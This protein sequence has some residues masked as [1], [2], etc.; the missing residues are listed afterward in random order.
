MP[1]IPE[2]DVIV[3]GG[4]AGGIAAAVS[5]ARNGAR[6][7]LFD[8]YGFLGGGATAML[9]NPFMPYWAGRT[10]IIHGVLQEII[11]RL[12][13]MGAYGHPKCEAAFDP[14][15]F[16]VVAELL[17]QEAGV[18]LLYHSVLAGVTKDGDR[19]TAVKVANKAGL[20]ELKAKLFIDSTGDGDLSAMAGA[21][22]EKG[23]PEDGL[24]QPMTL[25]FRVA[26]IDL[27]RMPSRGEVTRLYLEAKANGEIQ[28]PR[29]D[30]LFF[31]TTQ[32]GVIHFN[33][34]RVV[35][36]DAT[37]PW[38]LTEAEIEARRQVQ[39]YMAFFR[40]HVR[41]FENAYLQTTAPNI[42]VRESRRVIG[43][44]VLTAEELM[45]KC[46][47]DDVIAL[48]SYPIDIHNPAGT[49]T[50]LKY[51]QPGEYY[52]L[53]YRIL[54][55]KGV[56]NLLVGGRCVSCTHEAHSA[57]RVMPIVMAMA[58]AAGTAAAI[59]LADGVTPGQVDVRKLQARL[60]SQAA[61]LTV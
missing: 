37:D 29:E 2:F 32:P 21:V 4:G 38:A 26:N 45:A 8:R 43:E 61:T 46:R 41:G 47:F 39:Q 5:A 20:V 51:L 34:T 18:T 52:Q 54:V 36:K 49:G 24:A 16:K 42:G 7:L 9:V 23:R 14:E 53:P 13:A 11:D 40:K 17:C 30:V 22:V 6:T 1:I 48:G 55:P 15:A 31:Y 44:Y 3:A 33:T 50:V 25:N 60:V 56:A 28:C 59:C 58:Q 35:M 10:Q 19:I 27:D 12:T 57:I